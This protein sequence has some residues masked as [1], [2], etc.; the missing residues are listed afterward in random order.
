[1]SRRPQEGGADAEPAQALSFEAALARLEQ[2]ALR[3]EAGELPLEEALAT[4][5]QGVAL[6]RRC[7]EELARAERRL[8]H[9][10][11]GRDGE[12]RTRFEPEPA[13]EP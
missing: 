5:E 8:E 11:Q 6:S 7:A 9:L 10:V 12:Q 2:L 4:F 3:L 13:E 1:M